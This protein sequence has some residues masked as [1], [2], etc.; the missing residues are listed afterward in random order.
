MNYSLSSLSL[1]RDKTLL[2]FMLTLIAAI[3][4]LAFVIRFKPRVVQFK[5]NGH[6]YITIK[7][8]SVIMHDQACACFR[9]QDWEVL[10]AIHGYSENGHVIVDK[11]REDQ[12]CE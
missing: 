11:D 6:S 8:K 12:E 7:G 3:L 5:H 1:T 9:Q 10:K 4:L 2:I